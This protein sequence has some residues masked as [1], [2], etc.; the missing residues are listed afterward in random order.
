MSNIKTAFAFLFL[1][2]SSFPASAAATQAEADQIKNSIQKYIGSTAGVVVVSPDGDHY[3]LIFDAMPL[4]KLGAASGIEGSFTPIE[5]AL[6]SAGDGKWNV[7]SQSPLKFVFTYSDL[8]KYNVSTN[9]TKYVGVFDANNLVMQNSTLEFNGI[10]YAQTLLDKSTGAESFTQ[11][12]IGSFKGDT[13]S[14]VTSPGVSDLLAKYS[15]NNSEQLISIKQASAA[16]AGASP[17]SPLEFNI[18]TAEGTYETS[19]KA[20][21][22]KALMSLAAWFVAHPSKD[23]IIKDQAALKTLFKEALPFAEKISGQGS[24]KNM[25][26]TSPIGPVSVG[27]LTLLVDMSGFTKSASL[28]EAITIDGL[29]IPPGMLPPWAQSMMMDGLK[30]DFQGSGLDLETAFNAMIDKMDLTQEKPIPDDVMT[31]IMMGVL[32]PEGAKVLINPSFIKSA[33]YNLDFNGDMNI[34]VTGPTSAK[35]SISFKG[36]DDVIAK[37]QEAS[38]TDPSAAQAMGPLI[39]AKGMAKAGADGQLTWDINY[40]PVS[41]AVTVNGIDVTKMSGP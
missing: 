1:L 22:N 25:E 27:A 30:L 36:M 10:D 6:S 7:A 21:R 3:K 13:S 19:G 39:G 23:M 34:A 16:M 20:I 37:L 5:I 32:G 12:K 4:V 29:N 14:T 35:A 15:F 38:L 8:L 31:Q 18:K 9:T 28:R 40:D 17:V 24:L 2:G 41:K 26:A 11:Y 33:L